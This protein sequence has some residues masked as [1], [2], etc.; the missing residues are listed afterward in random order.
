MF[1]SF[2]LHAQMREIKY[3]F[4]AEESTK[5]VGR[6]HNMRRDSVFAFAARPMAHI[7]NKHVLRFVLL[8]LIPSFSL[9]LSL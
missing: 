9:M 2:Q 6:N 5:L 3:Q 1:L 4:M 8:F 7:D